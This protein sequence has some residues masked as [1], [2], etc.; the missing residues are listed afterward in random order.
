M[1]SASLRIIKDGEEL[2]PVFLRYISLLVCNVCLRERYYRIQDF[3]RQSVLTLFGIEIILCLW[4]TGGYPNS[5][6]RLRGLEIS[7]QEQT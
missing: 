6:P 4:E 1:F 7:Y 2:S 5:A 3:K